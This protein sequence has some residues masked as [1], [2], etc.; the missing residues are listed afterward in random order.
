MYPNIDPRQMILISRPGPIVTRAYLRV[1][2]DP[3]GIVRRL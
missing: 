1:F 2:A 3:N